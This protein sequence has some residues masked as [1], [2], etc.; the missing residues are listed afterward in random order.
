MREIISEAGDIPLEDQFIE[1]KFK[2]KE[3]LYPEKYGKKKNE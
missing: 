3:I 1:S 2:Y